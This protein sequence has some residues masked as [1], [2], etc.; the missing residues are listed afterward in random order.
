[1]DYISLFIG[2]LTGLAIAGFVAFRFKLQLATLA[3]R[4]EAEGATG[5][6]AMSALRDAA[7]Q[8]LREQMAQSTPQLLQLTEAKLKE[9]QQSSRAD[10]TAL[11]TPLKSHLEQLD[12]HNRAMEQS[13]A[14]AFES[15]TQQITGLRDETGKLSRALRAPHT[16]G[17]WG[18]VQ[19]QR[20]IE[21][22]GMADHYEFNMQSSYNTE[23]DTGAVRRLRPDCIVS[24]PQGK[25]V[26]IDVKT[27]LDA[28]LDAEAATD[29]DTQRDA[30][31]RHARHV[32]THVMQ[33]ADKKYRELVPGAEQ[34]ILF[35]PGE[36]FLSAALQADHNLFEDALQK[37][38]IL[39]STTTLMV[40]LKAYAY[41]WRQETMLENAQH[42]AETGRELFKRLST[43]T[44]H[45]DKVGR[46]LG[47]AMKSFNEAMGSYDSRVLSQAR[48]FGSFGVLASGTD[49]EAL[50]IAPVEEIAPRKIAGLGTKQIEEETSDA[51]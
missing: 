39:A 43:L 7:T 51:A 46:H 21:L 20:L 35:I 1:M 49:A 32:R 15:L 22:T 10:L 2:L 19:L 44:D 23:D 14:G 42:A 25:Q 40:L 3:A 34:V 30:L 31:L 5:G 11:L 38:V 33:L 6:M 27:P 17:R 9:T 16:R 45:F 4:A 18:E 8:A 37:N 36:H 13:R 48:K 24:L 12:L 47:N 28:Y 41:G 26:I 29:A 50:R